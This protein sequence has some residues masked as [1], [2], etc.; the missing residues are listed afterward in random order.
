[1]KPT[2]VIIGLGNPGASY[3][4]TRH[5]IGFQAIDVLS[6]EFGEGEWEDKQKFNSFIQEG[7]IVTVPILLV[8]PN[9]YMNRSGEAVR[10]IIDFYKLNAA[11]QI[12][13]LTDDV[14]LPLGDLRLRKKGGPGTHNGLKSIVETI[15]EGF[16]RIRVGLGSKPT[17]ADLAAWVLSVPTDE[18]RAM[19]EQSFQKIPGMVKEFVMDGGNL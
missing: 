12:L 1:M 5:N 19:F 6:K 16:S 10:K 7:R 4:R 18:E 8:K 9:T 14:D 11:E 13:I 15:G 17:G 2:L 3:D